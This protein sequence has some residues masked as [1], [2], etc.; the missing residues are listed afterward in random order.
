MDQLT[1]GTRRVVEMIIRDWILW[2]TI[3]TVVL[4]F[5]IWWYMNPRALEFFTSGSS[6]SSAAAK[7]TAA[8]GPTGGSPAAEAEAEAEIAAQKRGKEP[9]TA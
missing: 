6:S 8:A 2:V 9:T 1:E 5:T 4:A 3:A 7:K